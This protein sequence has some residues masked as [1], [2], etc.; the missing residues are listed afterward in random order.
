[1]DDV[2]EGEDLGEPGVYDDL[3]QAMNDRSGL[4]DTS[5]T[6]QDVE[7]EGKFP[8][9]TFPYGSI[10]KNAIHCQNSDLL[11][12][13]LYF[14]RPCAAFICRQILIMLCFRALHLLGLTHFLSFKLVGPW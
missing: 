9:L 1:M 10:T 6:D 3:A 4:D 7:D 12:A 11:C 13:R 8:F 5:D 14:H 2:E